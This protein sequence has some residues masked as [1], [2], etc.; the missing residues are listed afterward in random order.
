MLFLSSMALSLNVSATDNLM[1][2]VALPQLLLH[3]CQYDGAKIVT[4]G[5]VGIYIDAQNARLFLTEKALHDHDL[6]KSIG[7]NLDA[8]QYVK[9]DFYDGEHVTI[10][11][12]Y[13]CHQNRNLSTHLGGFDQTLEIKNFE[14]TLTYQMSPTLRGRRLPIT[15]AEIAAAKGVLNTFV[16]RLKR[17]DLSE[18]LSLLDADQTGPYALTDEEKKRLQWTLFDSQSSARRVL[19]GYHCACSVEKVENEYGLGESY[20]VCFSDQ[21]CQ[22]AKGET[23]SSYSPLMGQ[24]KPYCVRLNIQ[25]GKLLID[26]VQFFEK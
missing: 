4:T 9:R 17:S 22:D 15:A 18:V 2:E 3:S 7:V 6:N 8:D 20:F 13:D 10:S 23:F 26:S 25:G 5:F 19:A 11:G 1:K 21:P 24:M 12:R 16:D 14:P